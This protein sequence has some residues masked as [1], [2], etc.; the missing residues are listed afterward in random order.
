MAE[1]RALFE[2]ALE[3]E[4]EQWSCWP[5]QLQD[6]CR[7]ALSTGGKRVRPI[8]ALMSADA[9]GTPIERAMAWSIAVEL[10]HTYSLIHDDLPAMDDDDM[11]RGKPTVHRAFDEA[12]AILAGDAL[13]TRAFGVLADH[14][15]DE[16][17]GL[18]AH[19][20]GGGGMV[21]GQ[22][23]DL[24]GGLDSVSLVE[25]MQRLKTGALIRAA[26]VGGVISAGGSQ[27][28]VEAASCYGDALGLLFQITDDLLDREQ[29]AERGGNNVLHHLS[30]SEVFDWRDEVAA[31][32]RQAA[33]EF[34][35]RGSHLLELVETIA[36]RTV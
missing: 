36:R 9:V 12:T 4:F 35:D 14:G 6:A 21:G 32:G 22:I 24:G 10:V 28:Q 30:D 29:D 18:L 7:Y 19:A 11:R 31:K 20:S 34:G 23:L 15:S 26:A 1:L 25:S 8:L 13:L 33:S 2:S 27:M 3:T 5:P 16:L 17:S